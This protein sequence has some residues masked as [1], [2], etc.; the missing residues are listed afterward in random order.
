MRDRIAKFII[1][2]EGLLTALLAGAVAFAI[3][4][5]PAVHN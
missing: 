2:H 1:R 5:M 3:A 4:A